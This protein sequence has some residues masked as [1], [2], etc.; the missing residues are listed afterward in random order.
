MIKIFENT[1]KR[2]EQYKDSVTTKPRKDPNECEQCKQ[3][4]SRCRKNN[5]RE[6]S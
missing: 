6:I 3:L 1:L 5:E 2:T 4:Y